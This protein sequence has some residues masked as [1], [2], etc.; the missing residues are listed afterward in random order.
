MMERS[1]YCTGERIF[2]HPDFPLAVM[3][4]Q[5]H[6]MTRIAQ[7]HS[8]DFLEFVLVTGG[9]G[10]HQTQD[11]VSPIVQGNVLAIPEGMKHSYSSD[12]R[13]CIY[14]ILFNKEILGESWPELARMPGI[15]AML[16]RQEILR[17]P[18][19]EYRKLEELV[20]SLLQELVN[21]RTG[22]RL[23]SVALLQG[24][25][26]ELGRQKPESSG[27]EPP[28]LS[29]V[30]Q[31]INAAID[32][33]G[34]NYREEISFNRLAYEVKMGRSA[35]FEKFKLL[36]G[37]TPLEYQTRYRIEKAKGLLR[38][39]LYPVNQIAQHIGFHDVSY[40]IRQFRKY[41]AMTPVHYRES[42]TRETVNHQK[43]GNGRIWREK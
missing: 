23:Y 31:N 16:E 20:H 8:H 5:P 11:G 21:R 29:E 28:E 40:M 2:T 18:L 35:F 12:D 14:N 4:S 10:I 19:P 15:A 32:F 34:R 33:I 9:Y 39:T 1:T 41:E 27:E 7:L 13:L 3:H 24:F 43:D 26:I 38:T 25:L 36:T 30:R 37:A 17:L 6:T 42:I 22:F